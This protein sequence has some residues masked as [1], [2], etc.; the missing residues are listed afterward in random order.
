MP[1]FSYDQAVCQLESLG[2][3]SIRPGLERIEQ[4][5]ACLDHPERSFASIHVAGTNG[6]GS[7]VSCTAHLLSF[8]EKVG[9]YT[10]PHLHSPCERI[11]YC[12][13]GERVSVSEADFGR[14]FGLV[15]RLC[16]DE[17]VSLSYFEYLTVMAFVWF[18]EQALSWAVIEVGLGGR[19]DATN[20]VPA[21]IAALTSVAMDHEA[22]L[23]SSLEAICLEKREIIKPGQVV[24]VGALPSEL[25]SF[26]REKCLQTG[27][28]FFCYDEDFKCVGYKQVENGLE[29]D[30]LIK[31]KFEFSIQIKSLALYQIY[32]VI[33]SIFIYFSIKKN[34][35]IDQLRLNL[36]SWTWPG[37]MEMLS[38]ACF[39]DGAHNPAAI[40]AL[41][42]SLQV[43]ALKPRL[44][45]GIL[46]TKDYKTMIRILQGRVSEVFCVDGFHEQALSAEVLCKECLKNGIKATMI[47]LGQIAP[48]IGEGREMIGVVGSLYLVAYVRELL[49]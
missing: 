30:F 44:V 27:S 7:V 49:R 47:D 24:V 8:D 33:I 11:A 40:E 42:E 34:I 6:K 20:V 38:A 39:V 21:K 10:S 5:L 37:R 15:Y 41:G 9:L 13:K 3:F 43:L 29:F 26:V 1:N 28:E 45:L 23:G 14:L 12:F 4:V 18:R 22:W 32:N 16:A 35:D 31:N 25:K 46:Q 19:W 48:L 36:L 17:H 2:A